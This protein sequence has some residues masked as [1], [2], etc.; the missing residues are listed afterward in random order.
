MAVGPGLIR[1]RHTAADSRRQLFP[2]FIVHQKHLRLEWQNACNH[3]S[4]IF[5]PSTFRK[6]ASQAGW[7]GQAGAVTKLPSM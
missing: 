1:S 5:V 4:S 2:G 6:F 3:Q 7:A